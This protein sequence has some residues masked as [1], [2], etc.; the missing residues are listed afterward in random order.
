MKRFWLL[1]ASEFRL[2][3]MAIP[4][5]LVAFLQ[6]VV[7]YLLMTAVL[8]NPTFDVN[9]R[10]PDSLAGEAL[11]AAMV[12]VGSPI[13]AP[14]IN[15]ILV[16]GSKPSGSRQ[17]ISVED[18]GGQ[19]TAVQRYDLID[20]NMVKNYR[21]RLTAA[22]K[23]VWD[24]DLGS[25]AVTIVERPWLARDRSYDIYFGLAMLPLS[26]FMTAVLVGA[27]TTAGD[28]E[29][30]TILEYRLTPFPAGMILGARLVRLTLTA[31]IADGLMLA[32]IWGVAGAAPRSLALTAA[33]LAPVAIVAGCLGVLAGLIMQSTIPA[34]IIGLVSTFAG[35]IL[36]GAFG[37]PAGFGGGYEFVSRFMP[38]TY[39]VEVLFGEFY[40][41]QVAALMSSVLVL[42]GYATVMI[43][44]TLFV[45]RSRV[46]RQVQR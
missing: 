26:A 19:P 40:G 17:V 32:A 6:P 46:S 36:G 33:I 13:G 22:I 31:L 7:M 41:I 23:M 27:I 34:F 11:L 44:V 43:V 15:P 9:L 4:I 42:V 2:A 37:L 10:R 35:W 45:Y 12:Q 38:H 28:F 30:G 3:R 25:R 39:A 8:V 5:H 20:S 1:L 21:N 14:Y 16:D 24:D 29:T 18:Y